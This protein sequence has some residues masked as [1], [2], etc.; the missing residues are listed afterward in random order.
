MREEGLEPSR[1]AA[2]ELKNRSIEPPGLA[3]TY[4]K[5]EPYEEA[6]GRLLPGSPASSR[7]LAVDRA[8][9]PTLPLPHPRRA[10]RRR[11]SS[12]CR[13]CGRCSR[14]RCRT[15]AFLPGGRRGR[16]RLRRHIRRG[17]GP[18]GDRRQ[19]QHRRRSLRSVGRGGGERQRH[20]GCGRQ[21]GEWLPARGSLVARTGVD[22]ILRA[23]GGDWL[24]ELRQRPACQDSG[25]V[26]PSLSPRELG[27]SG[28]VDR[29]GWPFRGRPA[30]PST[31]AVK[32]ER[33]C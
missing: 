25:E 24:C 11:R 26:R 33:C 4:F 23:A 12:P 28:S 9:H 32:A 5:K 20:G 22:R 31:M 6:A 21:H 16:A 14:S 27:R 30:P 8:H 17:H 7:L 18:P 1:L 2:R 3:E 13:S 15:R 19:L 10:D 29:A